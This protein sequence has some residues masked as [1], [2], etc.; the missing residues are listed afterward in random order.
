MKKLIY[1]RLFTLSLPKK[2]KK[3]KKGLPSCFFE[4]L[5]MIVAS[6]GPMDF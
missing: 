2:K 1:V 4:E 5:R 3:K 6:V